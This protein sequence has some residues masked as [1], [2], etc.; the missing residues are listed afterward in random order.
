MSHR[1]T[2]LTMRFTACINCLYYIIDSCLIHL[3]LALADK[4]QRSSFPASISQN[5]RTLLCM[6]SCAKYQKQG[7]THRR[8]PNRFFSRNKAKIAAVSR[9][10]TSI[11]TPF[12]IVISYF[13]NFIMFCSFSF[14]TAALPG[15][16]K[17]RNGIQS[18]HEKVSQTPQ[19][20]PAPYNPPPCR[21]HHLQGV[22]RKISLLLP[23]NLFLT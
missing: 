13:C 1:R 2:F 15:S 14:S 22:I 12:I 8:R 4:R 9:R 23:W 11:T 16:P 21:F 20:S 5:L 10:P 17:S 18:H 3:F 6:A 19:T 7:E